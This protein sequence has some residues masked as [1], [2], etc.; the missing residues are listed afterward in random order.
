MAPA[1][2]DGSGVLPAPLCIALVHR[3]QRGVRSIALALAFC[4]SSSALA[5]PR[6]YL[7][8]LRAPNVDPATAELLAEQLVVSARRH[9]ELFEV[10]GAADIGALLDVEAAKAAMGCDT[11]SCTNEIADALNAEQLLAG[12]VGRIGDVWLLTMTRTETRTMKVLARVSAEAHGDAPSALLPLIPD[13]V[14]EALGAA[15]PVNVWPWI[16][17]AVGVVGALGAA[18]ALGLWG[19][20]HLE[21]QAAS[22]ALTPP[23]LDVE[24]AHAAEQRSRD[25]Y[26]AAVYTG[27]TGAALVVVGAGT[28]V[29]ALALEE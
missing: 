20:S 5:A 9:H 28:A 27:V 22:T 17:G 11:E 24:V 4:V 16:G 13:V 25:L 18:A 23:N 12:Q 21:F 19:W 14:D 26:T 6:V 3:Y 29:V 1:C 2:R 8:P 15:A 10:V 7:V